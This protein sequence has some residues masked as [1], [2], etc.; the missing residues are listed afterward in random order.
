MAND[1]G[2]PA[3]AVRD[4]SRALRLLDAL[5]GTDYVADR[6]RVHLALSTAEFERGGADPSRA[7]AEQALSLSAADPALQ[8][9]CHAQLA[10][11]WGRS[12][13]PERARDE[14]DL[15]AVHMHL[16][17]PREQW[18]ILINRGMVALDLADIA[19]ADRSFEAAA[20]LSAQHGMPRQEFMARHNLGYAAYVAGDLPRALT[21]M[22]A[23]DAMP[24]DTSRAA[25]RLDHGRVLLEAGLVR[26]AIAILT[27]ARALC[28][29]DGL[30]QLRGETDVE[31]AR[32]YLMT[33]GHN[34]TI[35][36]ARSA[37]RSFRQRGT[38]GWRAW[39]ALWEWA[40]LLD[41][42]QRR[43]PWATIA[44]QVER[45][46][47][48]YGGTR[49]GLEAALTAAQVRLRM[50]RAKV[51]SRW[52]RRAEP[53]ARAGSLTALLRLRL[54]QA[55]VAVARGDPR[56]P[57]RVLR[58][59]A[60][61]L[62]AAQ[63]HSGSLDVR[64]ATALHGVALAQF[65][66][67]LAAPRGATA[68]LKATERWRASSARIPPVRPPEDPE[69]AARIAELRVLG[70][71]LR[72]AA[73][74]GSMQDVARVNR[75]EQ[76]ISQRGWMLAGDAAPGTAGSEPTG[77]TIPQ[78]REL[79]RSLDA[80]LVSFVPL[81]GRLIAIVLGRRGARLHD[82]AD[83]GAVTDA[84]RRLD[85]DLRVVA[86]LPSPDLRPAVWGSLAAD[87]RRVEELVV[88]GLG[89]EGRLVV[90]PCAAIEGLPWGMLPSRQGQPTTIAQSL[91]TWADSLLRARAGAD[92]TLESHALPGEVAIP[93]V[94]AVA[95]PDLQYAGDEVA[96]VQ[97]AW[98]PAATAYP[99]GTCAELSTALRTAD[100]VH[101]A[102]HGLHHPQ[103]PLFS[104]VRLVD[105]PLFTFDLQHTGVSAAHVVLSACEVGQSAWRPGEER[106][107]LAA[108]LLALGVNSVIASVCRIP[109]EVAAQVMPAYHRRLAQGMEAAEALAATCEV[110]DP[111]AGAF[112]AMGTAWR[113]PPPT[114]VEQQVG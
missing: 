57:T 5:G 49:L 37:R 68:M 79:L 43:A 80:T 81:A 14:L 38:Q 64:T 53:I 44:G 62:A 67:Q 10:N 105:G 92:D 3:Q 82:V 76:A 50:G 17:P 25:S 34:Q 71:N 40:A 18:V 24:D 13:E 93:Q 27:D 87:L 21:L 111:M 4:L 61:E 103:S 15:A 107:G 54:V 83:L 56:A 41:Q 58:R 78:A 101:V 85:A 39:A 2:R 59:A 99:Q 9:M 11:V 30:R 104:S 98:G 32:G 96:Q 77:V 102:A 48:E 36:H 16:L 52:L 69:L 86:A 66:L 94:V 23:A 47:V 100:V 26:E 29:R 28:E 112:L 33:G 42:E 46:A 90:V 45:I 89:V 55:Q 108:G 19:T 109:D 113:L 97:R 6:V 114:R 72:G 51:A 73:G 106:L 65:D 91:T 95:G 70:E 7:H 63:S 75:L 31:L 60:A 12:H 88:S 8:A 22:A 74:G 1:T 84:L 35:K 20:Q 110:A